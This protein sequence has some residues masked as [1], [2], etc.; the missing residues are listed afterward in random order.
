MVITDLYKERL[1]YEQRTKEIMDK[2][3][4]PTSLDFAINDLQ[5]LCR[6]NKLVLDY[7][8]SSRWYKNHIKIVLNQRKLL[9]SMTVVLARIHSNYVSIRF[10]EKCKTQ[11]YDIAKEVAVIMEKHF[12]ERGI[13][14]D[15]I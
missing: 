1:E 12:S 7:W 9:G 15:T 14:I 11:S 6:K 8:K 3:R 13:R 2:P 10:N 5:E 4:Q